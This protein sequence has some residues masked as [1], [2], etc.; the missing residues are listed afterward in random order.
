MR[1]GLGSDHAGFA[2]K[3]HL[4]DVVTELGHEAIDFGTH[5]TE[6]VDYPDI[7]GVVAGAVVRG[8]VDQAVLVCGTGVGMAIAANKIPGVRA[9]HASDGFTARLA[10][11]HNDAQI[12]TLGSRV[13]GAGLAE[14]LVRTFLATAFEGGR[15][16]RRV[17][18][19]EPAPTTAGSA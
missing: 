12:L 16:A 19:L 10:R 14:D 6:S 7:A 5:S 17:A 4:R 2:L 3:A 9:A 11:A 18:K 8:E 1:V 13:V 15:H